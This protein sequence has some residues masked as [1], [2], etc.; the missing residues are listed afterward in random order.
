MRI[1]ETWDSAGVTLGTVALFRPFPKPV[2]KRSK[3]LP[4]Y[5][6][7]EPSFQEAIA[8]KPLNT[9][10]PLKKALRAICS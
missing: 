3:A 5:A 2:N 8:R 4:R 9:R 6:H 1:R 10:Q 7:K